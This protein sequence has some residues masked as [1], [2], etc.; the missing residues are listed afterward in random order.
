MLFEGTQA[1]DV[2]LSLVIDGDPE[3]I[4]STK[5][6]DAKAAKEEEGRY[7]EVDLLLPPIIDTPIHPCRLAEGQSDEG[8]LIVIVV[9]MSSIIVPIVFIAAFILI[10]LASRRHTAAAAQRVHA[11]SVVAAG[12]IELGIGDPFEG[13]RESD[14]VT[15]V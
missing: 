14:A 11:L 4:R 7:R 13:E 10:P 15:D 3:I 6:I 2:H 12:V 5:L 9:V 8:I 1:R